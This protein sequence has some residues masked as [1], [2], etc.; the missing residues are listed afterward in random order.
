MKIID[1]KALA[2]KLRAELKEQIE[3]FGEPIT[4]AVVMAG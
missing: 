4:L 3:N 2:A 1:G